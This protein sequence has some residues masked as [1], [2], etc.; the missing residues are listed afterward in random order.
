MQTNKRL[1]QIFKSAFPVPFDDT[2]RFVFFSD[3]HRGDDSLSDEFGRNRHIYEHAL[4]HYYRHGYTY[5]EVGDGDELW[6][7]PNY[8]HILTAHRS[9]FDLL[10]KYFDDGRLLI[11]YGNHNIQLKDPNYVKKNLYYTYDEQSDEMIPL[12][13]GISIHEALIL[14]HRVT[15]QEIFVVHGNQGDMLNDQFWWI[16][17]FMVQYIW[18]FLHLV[19]VNYAAS[20]AKNRYKRHKVE[21]NYN[22]WNERH[23]IMLICGHTHRPKFPKPGEPAYFNTGCCMHPRGITCLELT[24]GVI[25]YVSWRVHS[26]PDGTMYI[27]KTTIQG[28]KP[29]S[30]F[31]KTEPNKEGLTGEIR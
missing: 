30:C 7:H 3:V 19:G 18:R 26:K 25:S 16:S 12:F 20:P 1:D 5:I 8:E 2:S 23:G 6:E 15:N 14:K 28:P 27:R 17:R 22:K 29:L 31:Y 10:K 11:L 24:D 4:D 9:T 13:P 21:I